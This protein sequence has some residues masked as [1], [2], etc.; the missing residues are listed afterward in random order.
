VA[1]GHKVYD[2][3]DLA[4]TSK[5]FDLRIAHFEKTSKEYQVFYLCEKNNLLF[6][7]FSKASPEYAGL[8]A[9]IAGTNSPP[10]SIVTDE[11]DHSENA[12]SIEKQ[13]W[14]KEEYPRVWDFVK[15]IDVIR[16]EQDFYNLQDQLMR[17]ITVQG[18]K[19]Q[20]NDTLTMNDTWG[21]IEAQKVAI[22]ILYGKKKVPPKKHWWS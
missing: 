9:D 19:G 20:W 22:A 7:V 11:T 17:L 12:S 4:D 2:L 14:L 13:E 21:L 5:G 3:K 16:S 18:M 8:T 15:A 1:Q 10:Y 6:G